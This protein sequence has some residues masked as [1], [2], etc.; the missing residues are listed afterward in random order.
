MRTEFEAA[1]AAIDKAA[2]ALREYA[3]PWAEIGW[4]GAPMITDNAE[5]IAG[6]LWEAGV[7]KEGS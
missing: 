6:F 2:E 4:P 7:L 1:G 5:E 3:K